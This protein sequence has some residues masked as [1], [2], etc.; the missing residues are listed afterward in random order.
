MIFL[1]DESVDKQIVIKLRNEGFQVKY[2]AEISPGV[3][4]E[5]VLNHATNVDA[6]LITADKDFG[7]LV[8]RQNKI[9]NGIIL[10][11]LH[12][13]SQNEKADIVGESI[14]NHLN[15]LSNCFTV[16]SK[17]SIRIRHLLS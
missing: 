15:E 13:L 17:K 8:F 11:R 12:G 14:L 4:D 16:I 9:T 10:F 2:I 1:A 7:E 5:I 6:I 3:S